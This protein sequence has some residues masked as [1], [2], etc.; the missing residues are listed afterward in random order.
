MDERYVKSMEAENEIYKGISENV[1]VPK[2]R[3]T[4]WER[5]D[6]ALDW[7]CKESENVLDFGCGSG[8]LLFL[9]ANRGTKKHLGIDLAEEAVQYAKK[10]SEC[11]QQGEYEFCTGSIEQLKRLADQ[12]I[13][14]VILSNIL[15]NVYPDDARQ[16]LSECS[17]I[18]KPKGK[19]LVKLNPYVT[20]E[21]IT[22]W[23]MK[24]LEPEVYDDGFILWNRT[25]KDWIWEL[26][27]YF[28]IEDSYEF[29]IAEAEQVNR[30]FLL[31]NS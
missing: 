15:D 31:L 3:S 20:E 23:N 12:S 18:L 4:G 6:Q 24:E 7:L 14:S 26:Q 25:T 16:V 22:E 28:S 21:Q 29:Y 11:M 8:S 17:R 13:D 19:L 10:R 27:K 9:C 1:T 30:V 5:F 2:G